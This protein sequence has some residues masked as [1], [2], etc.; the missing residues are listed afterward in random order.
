MKKTIHDKM[1][2]K[3]HPDYKKITAKTDLKLF[4]KQ[5]KFWNKLSGKEKYQVNY[6]TLKKEGKRKFHYLS[7]SEIGR[8]EKDENIF[9]YETL[10]DFD[11]ASWEYQKKYREQEIK[12]DKK[13]LKQG[14][15]HL[16][17]KN[18][19]HSE[20][21]VK[22]FFSQYRYRQGGDWFRWI[23]DDELIY[24]EIISAHQY[25]IDK[26]QNKLN[27]VIDHHIPSFYWRAFD[28][29]EF[30]KEGKLHHWDMG[31]RRAAG[32]EKELIKIND[33]ARDYVQDEL[34]NIVDQ[35]LKKYSGMTFRDSKKST[36]PWKGFDSLIVADEISA[37]NLRM[38]SF[39][40]DF[41]EIEQPIGI[42]TN[43]KN[44]IYIDV[45]YTE[46]VKQ[47]GII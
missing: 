32:R 12:E 38:K 30:K 6:L 33:W 20:D 34:A 25:I 10:Y 11:K 7:C 44:R 27:K 8:L 42:L 29:P 37:K 22:K 31:T 28:K 41:R 35:R 3:S 14:K 16:S 5:E 46:M 1:L 4:E 19:R 21:Y 40:P 47:M 36:K 2:E 17:K 24:G 9:N 43:L 39:L 13:A 18:I 23:E 15:K 45:L 26:L